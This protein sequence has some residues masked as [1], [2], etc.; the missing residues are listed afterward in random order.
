M[1]IVMLHATNI[2]SAL[3]TLEAL[4]LVSQSSEEALVL[5]VARATVCDQARPAT[6]RQ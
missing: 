2:G 5:I 3:G 6:Q 1:S 4:D